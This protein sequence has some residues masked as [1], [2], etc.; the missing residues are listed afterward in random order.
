M[1]VKSIDFSDIKRKISR[2]LDDIKK[3]GILESNLLLT[4]NMLTSDMVQSYIYYNQSDLHDRIL[5]PILLDSAIKSESLSGGSGDTCLRLSIFLLD[6]SMKMLRRSTPHR[7]IIH[8]LNKK[9]DNLIK[10]IQIASERSDKSDIEV[11]INEFFK[12]ETHKEIVN[13]IIKNS[14]AASPIFVERSNL[15][16]TVVESLSG[17]NFKV[18]ILQEFLP[19]NRLWKR[20]DVNCLII[21]GIIESVG[22]IHHLL[23]FASSSK[24]SFI[25]FV[26]G[27]SDDVK[28]TMLFNVKRGTIDLIPVCVGFDENTLNILNDVSIACDS[29]IVSSYKGD[30]ISSAAKGP[31]DKIKR[32]SI[33]QSGIG[34]SSNFD[35][36]KLSQHI[37]FLRKKRDM[38]ESNDLKNL[39]DKRIRSLSSNKI[40]VRIGTELISEN[41]QTLELFDK[42]F[43]EFK[44]IIQRGI[45][46]RDK[47]KTI[48][49]NEDDML[50]IIFIKDRSILTTSSIC[51]ALK[52]S[53]SCVSSIIS[54]G[55]VILEDQ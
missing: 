13:E 52:I 54:V 6:E 36:K 7:E 8:N 9:I 19:T 32:V 4:K 50:E 55:N 28:N 30:L 53:S 49:K 23:E 26:R 38:S 5:K 48:F 45:I 29:D 12:S 3:S 20:D 46:T 37:K 44:M 40:A 1:N 33:S 41:S 2:D 16:D 34:I 25:L 51:T 17:F 10:D 21:D 27:L 14:Q 47:I 18:N 22:E 35:S 31:F 42:F 39:F 11:V 43:R 15:S 24:E